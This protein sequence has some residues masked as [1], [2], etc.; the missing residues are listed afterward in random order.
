M[1]TK[2][3]LFSAHQQLDGR[4]VDFGGWQLPVHYG[5]Q[6]EEHHAVRKSA[7]MFDVSHMTVVD[8]TGP[9]CGEFLASLLANNVAKL[10]EPGRALYTCMLNPEGGIIDD[11]IVYARVGNEFRLVVNAAT[12]ANDLAWINKQA[13]A[14]RVDVLE[15]PE[16]A[17][18]AAQGPNARAVVHDL[19]DGSI[20]DDVSSLRR[21]RAYDTPELFIARTGY[22][23]EDGFE[24]LIDAS[25]AASWWQQLLDAGIIPCGLGARDTLRLEA[26]LNLYGQDMTVTTSPA[27]SNLQWTVDF[28]G[29]RDFIGRAALV[30][31]ME[32]GVERQL[33]GLVLEGRGVLRH[34]QSVITDEGEGEVTSGTFSPTLKQSVALARVPAGKRQQVMVDIRGKHVPARVVQPPFVKAGNH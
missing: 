12:R 19:L 21:F 33:V 9:D 22:T 15:R 27:E 11:L 7:G 20:R 14:Y 32:A 18:I 16:I 31:Q 13:K 17:M 3:P 29:D 24:I 6:V 34:G 1:P 28:S 25:E 26:G 2:T 5:S 23:G 10:A 30:E 4:M 8:L